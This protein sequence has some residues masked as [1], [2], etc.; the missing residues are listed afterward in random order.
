MLLGEEG[1][2]VASGIL[3]A[4]FA[5]KVEGCEDPHIEEVKIKK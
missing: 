1:E 2:D 4:N 5:G 3:D